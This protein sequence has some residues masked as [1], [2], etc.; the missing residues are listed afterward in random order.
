MAK[1]ILKGIKQEVDGAFSA[2]TGYL[3]LVRDTENSRG[4]VQLDGKKYGE[5][6]EPFNE[7]EW[8]EIF[9]RT[10]MSVIYTEAFEEGAWTP[11]SWAED[12]GYAD[13]AELKSEIESDIDGVLCGLG[14]QKFLPT[15]EILEYDGETYEIWDIYTG[16][17]GNWVLVNGYRALVLKGTKA[18]DI[19]PNAIMTDST[20]R[21]SPFAAIV[22]SDNEVYR[23]PGFDY[24]LLY[25]E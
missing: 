3:Y 12:N 11:D 2:E 9:G 20:K 13:W 24:C 5:E 17:H 21:Y 25:A 23:I 16:D 6:A 14:S 19:M 15:D 4:Y 7:G 10:A 1:K 22:D 18:S 8:N